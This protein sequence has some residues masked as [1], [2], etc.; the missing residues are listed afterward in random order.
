VR[1]INK[2]KGE[3]GLKKIS[4]LGKTISALNKFWSR[5]VKERDKYICQ[6]CGKDLKNTPEICEAHHIKT[7][8]DFPRRV[9][10]IAN[11]IT[12]CNKCHNKYHNK[13]HA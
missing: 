11:G 10:D 9:Y 4:R 5:K 8:K 12:L 3:N 13:V 6:D 2:D 1:I 7:R